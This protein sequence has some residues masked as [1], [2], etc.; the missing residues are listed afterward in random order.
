M[1]A[2]AAPPVSPWKPSSDVFLTIVRWLEIGLYVGLT[3]SIIATI[4]FGAMLVLDRDRGQPVSAVSP[5]VRAFQISLG[6]MVMSSAGS[7]AKIFF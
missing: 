7:I 1:T 6:V 3:V 5:V 4:I 2:A